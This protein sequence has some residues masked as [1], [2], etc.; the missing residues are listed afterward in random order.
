MFFIF[1]NKPIKITA[2]VSE[3]YSYAESFSP[4][5]RA[6]KFIPKWWKDTPKSSFN[7]N[8]MKATQTISSCVGFHNNYKTGF[9]LPMWCELAIKFGNSSYHYHFSDEQSILER[10]DNDQCPGFFEN[11]N[12]CKIISPWLMLCKEPIKMMFDSPLPFHN[13]PPEFI[14]P[15]GIVDFIGGRTATNIFTCFSKKHEL[16]KSNILIKQ[17]QPLLH[18]IPLT[19]KEVD[20]KCEVVSLSEYNKIFSLQKSS[21]FVGTGLKNINQEK[22]QNIETCPFHKK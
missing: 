14:T 3:N 13:S 9:I 1:R 7:W 22:K 5:R 20:L 10:H 19:E 6:S 4:I 21:H 18:M 16:N 2:I 8:N 12:I 15:Y 11:Y 17:G